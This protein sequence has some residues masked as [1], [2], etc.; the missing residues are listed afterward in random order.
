MSSNQKLFTHE[1][2]PIVLYL[3]RVFFVTKFYKL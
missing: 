2:V 1:N 3:R